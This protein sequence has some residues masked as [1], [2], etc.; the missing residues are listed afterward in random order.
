MSKSQGRFLPDS[1]P[2]HAIPIQITPEIHGQVGP[3]DIQ[4]ITRWETL[5]D[6]EVEGV[7]T[8]YHY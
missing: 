4:G 7:T 1:T 3:E 6:G 5:R 2:L 8:N